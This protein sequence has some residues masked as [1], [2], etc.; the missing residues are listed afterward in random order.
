MEFRLLQHIFFFSVTGSSRQTSGLPL[1]D[2]SELLIIPYGGPIAT[3]LLMCLGISTG[4]GVLFNV[5]LPIQRL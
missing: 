3:Q 2:G 4:A 5:S 1:I